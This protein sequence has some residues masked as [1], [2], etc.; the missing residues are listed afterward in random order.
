M[1]E[2][3]IMIF[4]GFLDTDLTNQCFTIDTSTFEIK[5][6]NEQSVMRKSKKFIKFKDYIL[7][8]GKFVYVVDDENEIH[9]FDIDRQ[10]WYVVETNRES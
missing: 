3:Q 8:D 2:N 9:Q 5:R 1:N 7:K 4:G 10:Q 6:M